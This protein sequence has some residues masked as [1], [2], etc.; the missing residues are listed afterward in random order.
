MTTEVRRE[1]EVWTEAL[2][3]SFVSDTVTKPVAVLVATGATTPELT[4]KSGKFWIEAGIG[5]LS[6]GAAVE[7]SNEDE[8]KE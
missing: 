6:K 1:V 5:I 7:P 2:D 3:L 8:P 4:G